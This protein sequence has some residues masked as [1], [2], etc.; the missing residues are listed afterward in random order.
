MRPVL[1]IMNG[2]N[3]AIKIYWIK[4]AEDRVF[5]R[6][7]QPGKQAFIETTLGHRF[8]IVGQKD[9]KE[10]EV[11]SVVPIQAFRFDPPDANG[12]P[13]FY[14]QRTDA[15]GL[16]IVASAN[17]SPFALKEAAYLVDLMQ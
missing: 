8:A 9:Q 7:V 4:A 11:E 10:F 3:Q 6:E 15:G 12:I 5:N 17:V 1:Q 16:P 14:T 2:S 13:K